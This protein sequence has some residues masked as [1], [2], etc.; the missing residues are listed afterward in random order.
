ME[1][2]LIISLYSTQ[3]LFLKEYPSYNEC[4]KEL[5][6]FKQKFKHDKNIRNV[7]CETAFIINDEVIITRDNSDS[8]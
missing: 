5:D 8:L 4:S 6:K 7:E 2:V 1:W 3:D